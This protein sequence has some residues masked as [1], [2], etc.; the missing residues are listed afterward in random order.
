MISPKTLK[1]LEYDQIL[2]RLS[3]YC[4]N[5]DAQICALEL[6]P[7]TEY[8][9]A[10]YALSLTQEADEI[11]YRQGADPIVR[12]DSIESVLQKAPVQSTLTISE[13][14]RT[15]R[16]LRASRIFCSTVEELNAENIEHTRTFAQALYVDQ[17]FEKYVEKCFL[18]EE[19]VSDEASDALHSIRK[20]IRRCNEEI[21][22]TLAGYIH[23]TSMQKIMQDNLVTIRNG[24]YVIPVKAEFKGA[25]AGLIHDQSATGA[26]VFIE[27]ISIVEANNNLRTLQ[28]E[29]QAE[30]ERILKDFTFKIGTI[31]SA[32]QTNLNVLKECDLYFA[33]A[34]YA[35]AIKAVR[36]KLNSTGEI[37]IR[38]GRHPLIS[39][40]KVVPVTV[41]LGCGYRMLIITGPNTGGKT[42]TLKLTGLLCL[43]AMSGM[44]LPC[45]EES[46]ISVFYQIYCDIGDEQSIEQSLSTFSSHIQNISYI[47]DHVDEQTLVLL[48]EVGAGTDPAEGSALALSIAEFLIERR[49]KGIL[50]THYSELKEFALTAEGIENASMQFDPDTFAPTYKLN[51]GIPGSSNAIEIAKRLN[52]NPEVVENARRFVRR[53]KIEFEQIL[54]NAERAR[55]Q[56]EES[57]AESREKLAEYDHK[58]AEVLQEKQRL[59]ALRENLT[60]N[61]KAESKRIIQETVEEAEDIIAELKKMFNQDISEQTLFEARQLKKRL[62]KINLRANL[63]ETENRQLVPIKQDQLRKGMKVYVKSLQSQGYLQSCS[64]GKDEYDVMIGNIETTVRLKDLFHTAQDKPQAAE[65]S[66]KRAAVAV[67]LSAAQNSIALQ[68]LKLLGNTVDEAL[69][70]VD[71]FLDNVYLSGLHEAKIIHGVGTGVLMKAVQNHLRTHPLVESYRFGRYGEGERGVTIVTL[72]S[73]K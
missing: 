65:K 20:R 63:D 28:L 32:L 12:F 68:E 44:F 64:P 57:L 41:K 38:N 11:L 59:A 53:E 50:T 6:T 46:K 36:P 37:E 1:T 67:P 8:A 62:E 16:L 13:I 39:A 47:L 9:A 19:E 3:Q 26:T 25:V 54:Q 61:A 5:P 52:L 43:M 60:R 73:K 72:V 35:R 69:P 7:Y 48:D 18:S 4:V 58:L 70:K 66:A 2:N 42:V 27:P 10:E 17:N 15:A 51:I 21:K 40:D 55:F 29:E 22:E 34:R 56:A 23:S 30:I 31:C 49:C 24:R 14:L 71:I 45:G 33:K